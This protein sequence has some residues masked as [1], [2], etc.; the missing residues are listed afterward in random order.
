MVYT[1]R[2]LLKYSGGPNPIEVLRP[3]FGRHRNERVESQPLQVGCRCHKEHLQL[4]LSSPTIPR[5]SK[6]VTPNHLRYSPLN[7][8]SDLHLLLERLAVSLLAT[9]LNE[10]VIGIHAQVAAGLLV[11]AQVGAIVRTRLALRT[12]ADMIGNQ[13]LDT[14]FGLGP[15]D[16]FLPGWAN[17]LALLNIDL[18]VLQTEAL[19]SV[20]VPLPY[21]ATQVNAF[22]QTLRDVAAAHVCLIDVLFPRKDPSPGEAVLDG[23]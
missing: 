2:I 9:R 3:T 16:L 21:I 1:F 22:G 14:G 17:S 5:A 20:G 4:I 6:A 15:L 7:T 13:V 8:T 18:E 23:G 11:C 12:E 10:V 19:R